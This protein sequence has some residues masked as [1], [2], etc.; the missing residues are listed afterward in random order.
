MQWFK[1]SAVLGQM[2][3]MIDLEW[4]KYFT[5]SLISIISP[6]TAIHRKSIRIPSRTILAYSLSL[7]GSIAHRQSL[8]TPHVLIHKFF[9]SRA[10]ILRTKIN[11]V[12]IFGEVLGRGT[13]PGELELTVSLSDKPSPMPLRKID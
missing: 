9:W 7:S 10:R 4:I 2:I 11:D 5:D 12:Q 13:L 6:K 1:E 8:T 3:P